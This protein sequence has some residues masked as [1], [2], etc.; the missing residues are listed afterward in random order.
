M[1]WKEECEK[2]SSSSLLLETFPWRCLLWRSRP[3]PVR[4]QIR[5]LLY[6][7]PCL[8]FP[9]CFIRFPNAESG[10]STTSGKSYPTDS[11][12]LSQIFKLCKSASS[13]YPLSYAS[14]QRSSIRSCNVAFVLCQDPKNSINFSVCMYSCCSAL[15][16]ARKLCTFRSC[17]TIGGA[18]AIR[19]PVSHIRR[20]TR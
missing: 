16:S 9:W 13:K 20:C 11:S 5:D 14:P 15:R 12:A 18:K 10:E 3:F 2:S 4:R 7:E 19:R 1:S 8:C 17:L 6:R